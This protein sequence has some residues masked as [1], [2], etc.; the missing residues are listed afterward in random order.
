MLHSKVFLSQWLPQS[1][2]IDTAFVNDNG[3]YSVNCSHNLITSRASL[4]NYHVV[5]IFVSKKLSKQA[6]E[7]GFQKCCRNHMTMLLPWPV[8]KML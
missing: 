5:T 2:S 7:I 3:A 1:L 4:V 8:F 6:S